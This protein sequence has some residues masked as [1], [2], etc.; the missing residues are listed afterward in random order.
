[1][2]DQAVHGADRR[3]A[4]LRGALEGDVEALGRLLNSLRTY[5]I[6]LA[7]VRMNRILQAKLNPSDLV[8]ETFV[9]AQRNIAQFQG[10]TEREF[11]AWLAR[12][13][14]RRVA[15]AKRKYHGEERRNA[16]REVAL[17]R[18]DDGNKREPCSTPSGRLMRQEEA[19]RVSKALSSLSDDHRLVIQLRNWDR[20]PFAEIGRRMNRSEQAARL[21]WKRA[22]EQFAAA[23]DPRTP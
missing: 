22:L 23:L 8:Q 19:A 14:L 16:A 12:I 2:A 11:A 7:D 20:L 10:G 17:S 21:V 18:I 15:D 13:L 4:W 3:E 5:L 9:M 1:M 6:H